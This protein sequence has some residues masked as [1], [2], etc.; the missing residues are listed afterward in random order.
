MSSLSSTGHANQI[1]IRRFMRLA[2]PQANGCWL[3]TGEGNPA[4]YGMFRPGPGKP[5]HMAHRWSYEQY[6]TSPIPEGMEIDHTCHTND[7]TC[8]GGACPHRRCVNPHHLEAVTGSENTTR[9]RHHN[10]GKETCPRN[11]PYEGGN[12]ITGKDG[13]RRCRACDLERKRK[14]RQSSVG[15]DSSHS[16]NP[17]GMDNG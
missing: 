9:Q 12:L 16:S 1:E 15:S 6:I 10:R 4:G 2:K 17:G 14:A 5:R 7:L 13:R 3:W 8:P 11:H